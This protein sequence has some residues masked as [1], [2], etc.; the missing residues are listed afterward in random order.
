MSHESQRLGRAAGKPWKWPT[1]D[2]C[3][4]KHPCDDEQLVLVVRRLER[5]ARELAGIICRE[6]EIERQ[7]IH[8]P[9]IRLMTLLKT[10]SECEISYFPATNATAAD[11]AK[12]P[13][14]SG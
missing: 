2:D 13:G 8:E 4:R 3:L 6:C 12:G 11:A 14:R 7:P 9:V 5:L 10:A 1:E